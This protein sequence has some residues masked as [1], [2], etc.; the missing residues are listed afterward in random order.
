MTQFKLFTNV[1]EYYTELQSALRA[2]EYHIHM[3]YYTFDD[4]K[5][6]RSVGH[7]L[8]QKAAA[9]VTVKLMVDEMGLYLDNWQNGWRNRQLLA[10]LQASGIQV[11]MFRPRGDRLSQYNRL[12]CKFCAI[13][14]ITAF[15]GGSNI[16]EHY[17]DWR[18]TNLRLTGDLGNG[19]A[20]LYNSLYQFS[21][22]HFDPS[23]TLSGTR[24]SASHA[25]CPTDLT[26][27]EMPLLLTVPGHRQD[28]RRTLLGLILSAKTSVTLRSWYFFPDEEIMN[29]LLS[30]AE[31]G[32]RVTILFSHHTRMPFI[33][34]ANR[35]LCRRLEGAGVRVLRYN[36]RYMHAKEAWNDQGDILLGSANIDRW[37]L[38][39][40][41]ECCLLIRDQA[42]ANQLSRELQADTAYCCPQQN[43]RDPYQPKPRF[44]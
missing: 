18:D 32:V 40:N 42:L 8:A 12:H 43:R 28:I 21:N 9:G 7:I 23:T 19:F 6:A 26:I 17:L 31:K 44:S 24:L 11:D 15:I 20:L 29:A 33:D 1:E 34:I 38:R 13:D 37:A 14:G 4:G 3:A 30:Q 2:A 35:G 10:Q 16:G 5:I 22:G 41:F 36:G 25:A 39:T 27:A